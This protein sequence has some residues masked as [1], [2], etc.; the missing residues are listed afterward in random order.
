MNSAIILI[1]IFNKETKNLNKKYNK[2]TRKLKFKILT[3]IIKA[4]IL[5]NK[6]LRY[7]IMKTGITS[8]KVI[9]K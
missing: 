3:K 5:E 6:Y 2:K 9:E 7:L 8:I 1:R 4:K